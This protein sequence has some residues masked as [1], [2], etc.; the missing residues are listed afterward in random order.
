MG[1]YLLSIEVMRGDAPQLCVTTGA[2]AYITYGVTSSIAATCAKC[3][4]RCFLMRRAIE[5]MHWLQQE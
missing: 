5:Y 1:K 3:P 2:V 4:P